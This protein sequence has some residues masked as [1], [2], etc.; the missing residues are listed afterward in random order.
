[1]EAVTIRTYTSDSDEAQVIY[2]AQ[3]IHV[4]DN[5]RNIEEVILAEKSLGQMKITAMPLRADPRSICLYDD[6]MAA[7]VKLWGVPLDSDA[8]KN[9]DDLLIDYQESD[10][11]IIRLEKERQALQAQIERMQTQETFRTAL[12]ESVVSAA[13]HISAY[14]TAGS[15]LGNYKMLSDALASL[16]R[17]QP[18][19]ASTDVSAPDDGDEDES[20]VTCS[21]CGWTYGG[22]D[23]YCSV[24]DKAETVMP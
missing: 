6:A 2:Q 13:R 7:L 3:I 17:W 5:N 8:Q 15:R 21:E 24:K 18:D 10:K 19:D 12:L 4:R 9:Y 14:H 23:E 11:E 20:V 22:H 1:V 16:D